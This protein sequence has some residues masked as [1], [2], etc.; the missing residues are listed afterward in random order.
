MLI[1]DV[2]VAHRQCAREANLSPSE[3]GK[4]R[5]FS[6]IH[7]CYPHCVLMMDCKDEEFWRCPS[8]I[9]NGFQSAKDSPNGQLRSSSA[10]KITRDL[11]PAQR[12]I[13]KPGS[14]SMFSTLILS[15]DPMDGSRSL[16]KRKA[17]TESGERVPVEIRKR[18][19]RATSEV[20]KPKPQAGL[21]GQQD[22]PSPVVGDSHEM[23]TPR[24]RGSRRAAQRSE[25]PLVSIL[26]PRND[27]SL[28]LTIRLPPEKLG[29]LD[30]EKRKKRKR[31][32]ERLRRERM[33]RPAVPEIE[34]NHFPGLPPQTLREQYLFQE[35]NNDDKNKAK[36]YGG[37]L[38]DA[39]A[40]TSKTF[41]QPSDMRK[42]EDARQKAEE[43]WKKKLQS[44]AAL[45]LTRPTQK[46]ATSA[47][48]IKCINF[49]GYEIDTWHAAPYPEEYTR[50]R[51]LYICEFCLKY[52]NSDFVAWR[53]KVRLHVHSLKDIGLTFILSS[54]ALLSTL[55]VMKYIGTALSPSSKLM[56]AKTQ[57]TVKTY[58]CSL[59][60]SW[61]RRHCITTWS[62]FF[63]TS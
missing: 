3:D 53:H 5:Y 38:T 19:R 34:V 45:D 29:S 56:V 44:A 14:H 8:C 47:S 60:Y 37:I 2:P 10:P 28:T 20:D 35:N 17:S 23:S 48:K 42:F 50:N 32:Y 36:P 57:Y 63:S 24:T 55:L 6:F 16:R 54:N 22:I 39:E 49:G 58:V 61:A 30:H 4:S 41:P 52:M 31:E 13:P 1:F 7:T 59:S 62:R 12:G 27:D 51:I 11:L 46:S 25:R 15:D 9:E 40:D 18:P 26:E 33:Q 21:D 43:E